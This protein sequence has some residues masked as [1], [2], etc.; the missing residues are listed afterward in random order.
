VLHDRKA[1]VPDAPA[2][3]AAPPTQP[4]DEKGPSRFDVL[5]RDRKRLLIALALLL[6]AAAVAVG[7]AAIGIRVLRS[8][9]AR[10]GAVLLPGGR[11]RA[12]PAVRGHPGGPVTGDAANDLILLSGDPNTSIHESKAFVVD[13]RAGRDST[14]TSKL[15]GIHDAP[16]GVAPN[17]D[18]PAEVIEQHE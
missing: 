11:R 9:A 2:P 8:G 1:A 6:L 18:H 7:S 14:G 17:R 15:A 16:P 10:L 12:R 13:V 3:P 4:P 5:L